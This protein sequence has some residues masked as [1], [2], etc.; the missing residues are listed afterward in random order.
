MPRN[1]EIKASVP[2]FDDFLIRVKNLSGEEGTVIEQE[3]TFFNVPQGRLKLRVLQVK[4]SL[5][6]IL[7]LES[8]LK[9][10]TLLQGTP[11]Q[12]IFY[13]RPNADGPKVSDFHISEVNNPDQL[14]VGT[15]SIVYHLPQY[16]HFYLIRKLSD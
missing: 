7:N 2:D 15:V 10:N 4:V 8:L 3:D 16:P 9:P 14:K 11:S 6:T 1:V 5:Q 12:L 13:E